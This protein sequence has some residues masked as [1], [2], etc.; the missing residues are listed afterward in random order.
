MIHI[1]TIDYHLSVYKIVNSTLNGDETLLDADLV[2]IGPQNFSYHWTNYLRSEKISPALYSPYSDVIRSTFAPRLCEIETLLENRKII[3]T[4]LCP[5][6]GFR[7]EIND[8]ETRP[9]KICFI[10]FEFIGLA[11]AEAEKSYSISPPPPIFVQKII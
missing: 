8:Q 11:F 10:E 4:F 9:D 6:I 7:A 1:I 5:V 2:I 3:I